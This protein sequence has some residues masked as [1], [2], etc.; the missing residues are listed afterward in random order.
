MKL[1]KIQLCIQEI[2]DIKV[3]KKTPTKQTKNKRRAL[4]IL[5]RPPL[6]TNCICVGEIACVFPPFYNKICRS[7]FKEPKKEI[8]VSVSIRFIATWKA[9]DLRIKS[10]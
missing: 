6:N 7:P 5:V 1:L 10:I 4:L 3:K 2:I 9:L 8:V